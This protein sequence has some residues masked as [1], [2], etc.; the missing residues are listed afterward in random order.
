MIGAGGWLGQPLAGLSRIPNS[1]PVIAGGQV[2]VVLT[3]GDLMVALAQ[4]GKDHLVSEVMRRDIRIA[5]SSDMLATAF[6]RLQE[7][8]C[9]SLP[10]LHNGRLVG[11]L[12][13]ENVGEFAMVQSALSG[14]RL[15]G[16]AA[17]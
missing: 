1:A 14:R 2:K 5:D 12:T 7:C 10:V 3:K 17:A 9:D 8:E 4:H 11:L 13:S 6:E 15:E 16:S